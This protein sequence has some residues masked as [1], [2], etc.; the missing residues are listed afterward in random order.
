[1]ANDHRSNSLPPSTHSFLSKLLLFLTILSLALAAIA[2]VLQWRGGSVSDPT[3]VTSRWAP[4]GSRREVFPGM[5]TSSSLPPK[6]NHSSNCINLGRSSSPSFPYYRDWKFGFEDSLKPKICITTS[7]SA[8]LVQI[9]PW[10]F[11]HKVIGVRTFYLFV[12]GHA[13]SPNVSRVLESIPGVKVIYRT[14]ELEEQQAK[15]RIWNETWLSSFF[16]KPCNYELFVKQS[17]NMENAIFMAR[18]AGMDWIIHLDTDELI[19]PAGASEYSL[20]Q[21]LLDLPSDVDLVVFPNYESSVERDDIKDPFGEV[22]MFKKNYDHLPKETYFG[23]YR[24]ATRGNPNYFLTYGNG[25]EAARVQ[26]ELRP[27]GAHRWH[28]YMKT[29]NE[30]KLD[31]AAVLH[32]TYAKFSDLTSRRDRC[33]CKPTQEDVKRCFMLEFDRAAFIIASTATEEELLHWY[34]EHVVWGD[35]DLRLKLL[36]KGILTRIYTPMAIIQALRES[37]VFSSVIANAPATLS[38]DKF[39]SSIDSSNSSRDVPSVSFSSRKIGGQGENKASARKLLKIEAMAAEVA[40]V[41]PLSPPVWTDNDRSRIV[42]TVAGGN[43]S[44]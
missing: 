10:M 44:I 9:L 28:N 6:Y 35:K 18:D 1:M 5:E 25:K 33:G 11:Y 36:R 34:R 37:G 17:L 14:K 40:A 7:T 23:L 16:Y 24:E 42:E 15:S 41:P 29:P 13:A 3:T 20:R 21:V 4:R 22:S 32:Y 39:M 12:E 26:D 38:R 31:N 27:N 2:F 8:G 19:Y 30:I 43:S